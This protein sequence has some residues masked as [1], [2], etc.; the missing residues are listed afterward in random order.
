VFVAGLRSEAVAASLRGGSEADL[1][2]L[3]L[4]AGFGSKASFNRAF[5]SKYGESPSSYRQRHA[6]IQE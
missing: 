3:A 4:D 1:L 2:S 5:Q 6:S